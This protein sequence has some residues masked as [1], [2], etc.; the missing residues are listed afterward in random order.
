MLVRAFG[1]GLAPVSEHDGVERRACDPL[2]LALE[3]QVT[4]GQ[5]H[6]LIVYTCTA[7]W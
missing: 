1:F 5:P 7:Q 3:L 4:S 2:E 6:L